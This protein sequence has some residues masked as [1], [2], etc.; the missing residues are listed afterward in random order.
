MTSFVGVGTIHEANNAAVTP[1]L[2]TGLAAGD[3]IGAFCYYRSSAGTITPLG[4]PWIEV[5]NQVGAGSSRGYALYYTRAT[6][7]DVA[8]TFNVA[9]GAD[10]NT[11]VAYCFAFRP[12][13]GKTLIIDGIG[14][15]S[16]NGS[17]ANVGPIAAPA[18]AGSNGAMIYFGQR[19]DDW[20]GAATLSGD[21]LTWVEM[22]DAAFDAYGDVG[23]VAD[24]ALFTSTPTVTQKTFTI[25]G[26]A[27]ALGVGRAVAF[28]E[29]DLAVGDYA[30]IWD[31]WAAACAGFAGAIGAYAAAWDD[32]TVAATG[33]VS[34]P[35]PPAT[36]ALPR[37]TAGA[38]LAWSYDAGSPAPGSK[39]PG[40]DP[41]MA[42][43]LALDRRG[44]PA[45][46]DDLQTAVILSLGSDARAGVDDEIPDGSADRRGWWG[47]VLPPNSLAQDRYGSLLWLLAREKQVPSV[48][49]RA[50]A[51]A[52]EA[53]A[54]LITDG[55]ASCVDV[56]ASFPGPPGTSSR[57]HAP[58]QSSRG[59]LALEV[60]IHRPTAPPARYRFDFAWAAQ[61][62]RQ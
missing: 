2:P 33:S 13:A 44:S 5:F 60:A 20:T 62:S 34:P 19:N 32:W 54:W 41:G 27:A 22:L 12:T 38:D 29:V 35:S 14:A 57:G 31:D 17:Q 9:G 1:A 43:D 39:S 16:P 36:Y 21:G 61:A 47:D 23:V 49:A 15:H 7:S 59:W 53:L 8:P 6:G 48:L 30:V 50:E 58:E 40:G 51:F 46:S 25:T 10:Q 56:A 3:L 24:Y 55:I 28:K 4:G 11:V 37:P 18:V 26:G 52:R 42:A 45:T